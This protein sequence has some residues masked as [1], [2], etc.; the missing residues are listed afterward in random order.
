MGLTAKL[1][2]LLGTAWSNKFLP[3]YLIYGLMKKMG[4]WYP[5]LF[6]VVVLPSLVGSYAYLV[7]QDLNPLFAV[8]ATVGIQFGGQAVEVWNAFF[9]LQGAGLG[10]AFVII[11][12]S[13][14]AILRL[15]WYYYIL[16]WIADNAEPTVS[17]FS[18]AVVGTIILGMATAFALL[19]DVYVL[20]DATYLSGYTYVLSNPDILVEPLQ[21]FL[22]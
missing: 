17:N 21:Q 19:V 2:S 1:L 5:F 10:E 14:L 20:Q 11:T 9:S 4:L 13:S 8:I 22:G 16:N 3:L 15:L 6:L 18:K 12:G 7:S